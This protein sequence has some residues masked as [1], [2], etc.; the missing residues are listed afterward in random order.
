MRNESALKFF[1]IDLPSPD[2]GASRHVHSILPYNLSRISSKKPQK[3][4][5]RCIVS[6]SVYR[7]PSILL[8]D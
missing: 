6:A 2:G 4:W 8:P 1:V 5:R 3:L 7:L